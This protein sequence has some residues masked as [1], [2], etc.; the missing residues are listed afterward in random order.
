MAWLLRGVLGYLVQVGGSRCTRCKAT[1]WSTRPP[2]HLF[3][4]WVTFASGYQALIL[5]LAG[6]VF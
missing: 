4:L 3:S 1:G 5:V 6:I 2:S